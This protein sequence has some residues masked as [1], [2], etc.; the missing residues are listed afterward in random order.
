MKNLADTAPAVSL[1]QALEYREICRHAGAVLAFTNGCFDLFHPG[2]KYFIQTIMLRAHRLIVAVNSDRGVRHL[3]GLGRPVDPV[4]IRVRNLYKT[5]LVHRVI[6][7]DDPTPEELIRTL[8]PDVLAKGD[9]YQY[10][11]IVGAD[12]VRAYGGEVLRIPRL[13]GLST[14]AIINNKGSKT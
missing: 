4:E 10:D 7:F 13:P 9:D 12:F 6:V 2:H 11:D 3:K 1:E 14:T 8:K 5:L